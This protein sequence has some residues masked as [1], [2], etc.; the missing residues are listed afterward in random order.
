MTLR[1]FNLIRYARLTVHTRKDGRQAARQNA[2]SGV[3]LTGYVYTF[4]PFIATQL[5]KDKHMTR[6]F[7]AG[8]LKLGSPRSPLNDAEHMSVSNKLG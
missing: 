8:H 1:F 4:K 7:T 3:T 2:K 6:K 5:T